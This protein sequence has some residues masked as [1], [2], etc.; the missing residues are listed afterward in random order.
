MYYMIAPPCKSQSS[1]YGES[2]PLIKKFPIGKL[3]FISVLETIKTSTLPLTCSERISNLFRKVQMRK[4]VKL[5][6]CKDF[7]TLWP[8]VTL[9]LTFELHSSTVKPVLFVSR[10][11]VKILDN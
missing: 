4:Q 10:C 3:S 11:H 9:W 2:K 1:L 5:L 6:Q 7:N 8:S